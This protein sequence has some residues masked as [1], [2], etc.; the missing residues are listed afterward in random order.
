MTRRS[1]APLRLD[2]AGVSLVEIMV[3]LVIVAIGILALV[4]VQTYSTTDVFATGQDTRA[5]SIGQERMEV[6]RT[7]GFTAAVSDSGTVDGF[8]WTTHVNNV[9]A[10][11]NQV[12]VT[13]AWREHGKQRTLQLTNLLSAR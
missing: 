2:S 12:R 1:L 13:V 7:A 8:D 10:G 11:L 6:A 9:S 3:V 4:A 5:L